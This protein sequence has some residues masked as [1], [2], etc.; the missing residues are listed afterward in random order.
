MKL[1]DKIFYCRKKSGMSQE[2]L[3]EK[4]CV[5]RQA[6]S[7]W[8]CGTAVPELDN[9]YALSNLFGVTTDWLLDDKAEPDETKSDQRSDEM[10]KE[11][12]KTETYSDAFENLPKALVKAVRRFGWLFGVYISCIG[13]VFTGFGALMKFIVNKML[14]GFD[15]FDNLHEPQFEIVGEIPEGLSDEILA[16]I[17]RSTGESVS[18]WNSDPFADFA[19]NNPVSILGGVLIA[20]GVILIVAGI[21]TAIV[22]KRMGERK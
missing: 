16:E 9:L 15:S 21:V 17:Y 3:A 18:S 8:E 7:K 12:T 1:N 4:L 11:E 19:Q 2:D 13:A 6:I 20:I 5:S 22:L 14:S 10:P